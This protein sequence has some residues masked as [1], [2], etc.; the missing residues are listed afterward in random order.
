[1]YLKQKILSKFSDINKVKLNAK[2]YFG[3]DKDVYISTRQN[4]KYMIED[5]DGN[6]VHFG[7]FN[8]P[9]EDYTKHRDKIRQQNY[10]NR[11]YHIRGDWKNN[12]YSPNNLSIN[13]LW[14]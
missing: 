13:L 11:A 4:K 2:K 3:Y 1:M 5:D 10:L 9:M 14:K 8:P 12:K 7:S 6:M